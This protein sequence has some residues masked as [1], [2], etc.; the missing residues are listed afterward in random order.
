MPGAGQDARPPMIAI[1]SGVSNV[2]LATSSRGQ[3]VED[4]AVLSEDGPGPLMG[5]VD[6][7]SDLGV[8]GR[9]HLVGV[10]GAGAR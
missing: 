5:L 10:H 7:G 1:S 6:Q 9:R 2:S 8:D 4:A 3:G